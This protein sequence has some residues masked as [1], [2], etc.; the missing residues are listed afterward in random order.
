MFRLLVSVVVM[1]FAFQVKLTAQYSLDGLSI[2]ENTDQWFIDQLGVENSGII[3]GSFYQIQSKSVNSHPFFLDKNRIVG[4]LKFRG[5][6]YQ[7]IN[8][9][10]QLEDDIILTNNPNELSRYN[11]SIRLNGDHVEWFEISNHLFR[12]YD[13]RLKNQSQGF[14][15]VI[16]EGPSLKLLAKHQVRLAIVDQKNEYLDDDL[17]ILVLADSDFLVRDRASWMRALKTY[18]KE[19]K[20]FMVKNKV[21]KF[22]TL[23]NET[24][25]ALAEYSENL[26][27]KS[28]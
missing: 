6:V 23:D 22:E 18:K 17:F 12:K 15:E 13:P 3:T 16:Y 9:S 5:Q 10:Y 1:S 11:Q 20:P 8:L 26:I 19:L 2:S 4:S 25:K 14:Y 7:N 28:K 21:R 27:L 24:L